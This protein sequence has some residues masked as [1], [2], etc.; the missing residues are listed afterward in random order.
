MTGLA[1][2]HAPAWQVSVCVQALLSL[3]MEPSAAFAS[4][5]HMPELPVHV[6]A[7]SH[8]PAAARQTVAAD[9]NWH[10]DEQQSPFAVLPSSQASPAWSVPLPHTDATQL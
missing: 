10:V 3:H 2:V 1:P 7:T 5:G 9:S 4:A 6:S 8:A